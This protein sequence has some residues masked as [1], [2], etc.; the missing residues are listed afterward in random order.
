M[1]QQLYHQHYLHSHWHSHCC[2][3][4]TGGGGNKRPKICIRKIANAPT[5]KRCEHFPHSCNASSVHRIAFGSIELSKRWHRA[6]C[7][8][9]WNAQHSGEMRKRHEKTLKW[10]NQH[11]DAC[12]RQRRCRCR[13]R[14]P[15]SN[16][17]Q[18]TGSRV[19]VYSLSFVCSI[20][21][22]SSKYQSSDCILRTKTNKRKQ[23]KAH[24]K[25]ETV[26]F[27]FEFPIVLISFFVRGHCLSMERWFLGGVA[28]AGLKYCLFW[29][30]INI[31]SMTKANTTYRGNCQCWQRVLTWSLNLIE[32]K[33]VNLQLILSHCSLL[34]LSSQ[35]QSIDC[36]LFFIHFAYKW[37]KPVAS[38]PN[39]FICR[40]IGNGISTRTYAL[41]EM[42]QILKYLRA[43]IRRTPIKLENSLSYM[44]VL[45]GADARWLLALM[46]VPSDRSWR[47]KF[48]LKI[49]LMKPELVPY[50]RLLLSTEWYVFRRPE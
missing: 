28:G 40:C 16:L 38:S 37:G 30:P 26:N 9:Q 35:C 23:K 11:I 42:N 21:P 2:D 29:F 36:E 8:W 4:E 33:H 15:H 46:C 43:A 13:C 32:R 41:C 3:E 49:M 31:S 39:R 22:L 5:S 1:R 25:H 24:R 48:L 34:S 14:R 18:I 19:S 12:R 44:R 20:Y 6:R 50:H 27:S 47:L 45:N 7:S 17:A 10:N